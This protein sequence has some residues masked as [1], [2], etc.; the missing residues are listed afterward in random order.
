MPRLNFLGADEYSGPRFGKNYSHA[1][2][3]APGRIW[4]TMTVNGSPCMTQ[5]GGPVASIVEGDFYPEYDDLELEGDSGYIRGQFVPTWV[6]PNYRAN[7]TLGRGFHIKIPRMKLNLSKIV[8]KVKL[9]LG[10]N[11]N[12]I[13]KSGSKMFSSAGKSFSHAAHNFVNPFEKIGSGAT[14]LLTSTFSSAT[15]LINAV[16]GIA[17]SLPGMLST[18]PAAAAQLQPSDPESTQMPPPI[19]NSDGTISYPD[20]SVGLPDGTIIPADDPSLVDAGTMQGDG[21]TTYA[22]GN[23]QRQEVIMPT[24]FSNY[25]TQALNQ[26]VWPKG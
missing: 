16:P 17:Q 9:K 1:R 6:D 20:G 15:G 3:Q 18:N 4:R 21:L 14:D 23:F 12:K 11:P 26:F 7:I 2:L 10:I 19:Q 5:R 22:V 13:L 8:P 24:P 25:P